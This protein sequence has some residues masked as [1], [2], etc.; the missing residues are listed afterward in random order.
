MNKKEIYNEVK[1]QMADVVGLVLEDLEVSNE[2][3]YNEITDEI[4]R[5]VYSFSKEAVADAEVVTLSKTNT[6]DEENVEIVGVKELD[7]NNE[8]LYIILSFDC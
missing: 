1:S 2:D 5:V 4:D 7:Y 6:L 3:K 8:T